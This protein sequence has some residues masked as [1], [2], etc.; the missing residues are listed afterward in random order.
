MCIFYYHTKEKR[1]DGNKQTCI[2]VWA[3]SSIHCLRSFPSSCAIVLSKGWTCY[4]T[5][6]YV[7]FQPWYRFQPSKHH[8]NR[9]ISRNLQNFDGYL[10]YICCHIDST[11]RRSN[12]DSA[13][14]FRNSGLKATGFTH[15]QD[16]AVANPNCLQQYE[17]RHQQAVLHLGMGTKASLL[18]NSRYKSYS[19]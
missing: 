11:F 18:T 19:C 1:F 8:L 17:D 15:P 9:F 4:A 12:S 5:S 10:S 14:I 2:R 7:H 16:S 6:I 3:T 13:S